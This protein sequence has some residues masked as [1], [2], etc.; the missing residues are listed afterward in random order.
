M[1]V[2]RDDAARQPDSIKATLETGI[3]SLVKGFEKECGAL[4]AA[5]HCDARAKA[6]S[7]LAHSVGA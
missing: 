4:S 3:E 2:L 1:A 5:D 6:F 7:V